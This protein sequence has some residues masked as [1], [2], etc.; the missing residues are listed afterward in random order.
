VIEKEG[1]LVAR[2]PH[3]RQVLTVAFSHNG[4]WLA[5]GSHDAAKIWELQ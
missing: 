5:T 3:E 2:M 4:R 1:A